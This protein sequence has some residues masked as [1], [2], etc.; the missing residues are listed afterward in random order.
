MDDIRRNKEMKVTIKLDIPDND[1]C[2]CQYYGHYVKLLPNDEFIEKRFCK[3]FN[4]CELKEINNKLQRCV[5]CQTCAKVE[6]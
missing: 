3:L 6:E 4:D 5:A 2:Y 1:C